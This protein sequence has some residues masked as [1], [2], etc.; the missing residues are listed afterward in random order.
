[1]LRKL[2]LLL[3]LGV[4]AVGLVIIKT[5][6]TKDAVCAAHR[7]SV[8]A[9]GMNSDCLNVASLYFAGFAIVVVGALAVISTLTFMRRKR[10]DSSRSRRFAR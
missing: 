1:M 2:I 3:S 9:I 5:Q 8:S 6:H 10:R 4:V 7:G